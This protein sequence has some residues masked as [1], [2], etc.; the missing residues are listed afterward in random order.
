MYRR[1]TVTRLAF[2][3]WPQSAARRHSTAVR[4]S[5]VED[6]VADGFGKEWGAEGGRP[7]GVGDGEGHLE[8]AAE[9]REPEGGASGPDASQLVVGTTAM[10]KPATPR[11]PYARPRE[12]VGIQS[13]RRRA[14]LLLCSGMASSLALTGAV[15][16]LSLAALLTRWLSRLLFVGSIPA[17]LGRRRAALRVADRPTS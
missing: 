7:S 4:G 6:A 5:A 13:A 3:R 15:V 17:F 8:D 16:G 12:S 9:G 14:V 11:R 10:R 2:D 1:R